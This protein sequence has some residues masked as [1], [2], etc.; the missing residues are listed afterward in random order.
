MQLLATQKNVLGLI[1]NL[2]G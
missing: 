2:E 1:N